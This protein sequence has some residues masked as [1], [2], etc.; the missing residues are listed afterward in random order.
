MHSDNPK[1]K[2]IIRVLVANI[3]YQSLHHPLIDSVLMGLAH[4]P[5]HQSGQHF[6]E[7][8]QPVTLLY[9]SDI[10]KS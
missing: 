1:F 5:H 4:H 9:E 10:I 8:S 2:S 7:L 3:L 6:G